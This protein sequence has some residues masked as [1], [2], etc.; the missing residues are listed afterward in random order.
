[1]ICSTSDRLRVEFSELLSHTGRRAFLNE[2]RR[3]IKGS[4]VAQD[5]VEGQRV[6][7]S[8]RRRQPQ[9]RLQLAT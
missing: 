2:I 8:R 5:D 6:T 3:A 1:M 9:L 4:T 7:V